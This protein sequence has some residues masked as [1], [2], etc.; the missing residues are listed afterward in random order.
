[1]TIAFIEGMIMG[2]TISLL[3]GPSFI[4][5]V[6]TSINRGLYSGLQVA[7][8]ISLSDI[9]LI[10]LSYVGALK[11]FSINNNQLIFGII[12]G[13]IL[14]GFGLWTYS[15]KHTSATPV[16]IQLS[17]STSRFL[18]YISKGFLLNIFNPFVFLFWFGVMSLIGSRYGIPSR[19]IILFFAGTMSV[20]FSMDII[21]CFV[22]Q[23]IRRRL[24]MKL[25]NLLNRIVGIIL[26]TFGIALISRVIF[27]L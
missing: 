4:S 6:Q 8:G 13:S 12:G 26:C 16:S 3:I 18:K 2:L 21:K 25:L 14:I 17:L 10:A 24:N 27:F 23:R 7:I 9:S 15:R 19:E 20:I 11:F 22:A 5:L 1:M